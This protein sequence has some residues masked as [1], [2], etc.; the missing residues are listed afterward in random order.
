VARDTLETRPEVVAAILGLNIG[1][2][3]TALPNPSLALEMVTAA[4][5]WTRERWL[6][7]RTSPFFGLLLVPTHLPETAAAVIRSEGKLA[8]IVG[9]Q[10]G[11]NALG[12]RFGN[13]VY[14]S[15]HKAAADL[16]L[17]LV[18][19]VRSDSRPDSL[20]HPTPGGLPMTY[21]EYAALSPTGLM[22][23][24]TNLILQ[25][26]FEEFP[27][28]K[29]FAVG[30]GVTWLP[31][32]F[33]KLDM[34]WRA[35]RREVPWL[36][37]RPSEYLASHV[38]VSTYPLESAPSAAALQRGLRAFGSAQRR[39]CYASGYPSWDMQSATDV[40]I[41]LPEDWLEDVNFRNAK[42]FF[43]W[44]ANQF[45]NLQVLAGS[46]REEAH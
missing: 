16:D 35:L 7:A 34:E 37:V 21:G 10:L 20:T 42:D 25:G 18:L 5:R 19:S 6:D 39:L 40:A 15:I 33:W 27:N 23:H 17:P 30:A 43:R 13:P 8:R 29:V 14:K 3:S 31:A 24:L 32:L 44:P 22:G 12:K 9:I 4:N 26:V 28:L 38:R 36:R 41:R 1:A 45:Q 11:A 2:F 46:G